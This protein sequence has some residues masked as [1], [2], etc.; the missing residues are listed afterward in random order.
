MQLRAN[1]ILLAAVLGVVSFSKAPV[2]DYAATEIKFQIEGKG[3]VVITLNEEQAPKTSAQ[4][5]R[6]AE[7]GF[8]TGQRFFS[9][10]NQPKPFLVKFGDPNSKEGLKEE[11]ALGK[12]G[13]GTKVPFEANNLP[14]LRGAVGLSTLPRDPN[15]GDSIF[16]ICLADNRFLDGKYTIFG[17]VSKGMEVVDQIQRGDRVSSVTVVRG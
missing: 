10:M 2:K 5:I 11:S 9:V 14:N 4:I 8:Y 17:R 13:S 7:S 12:S 15:S 6:L 3:E 1:F 16:Y